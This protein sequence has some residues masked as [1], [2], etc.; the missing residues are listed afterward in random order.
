MRPAG[1]HRQKAQ[2]SKTAL[3]GADR[4]A[5]AGARPAGVVWHQQDRDCFDQEG[6]KVGA[7]EDEGE[8]MKPKAGDQIRIILNSC[9]GFNFFKIFSAIV[10]LETFVN[11][12]S[13]EIFW[14]SNPE[15]NF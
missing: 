14:S 4:G 1:S 10:L 13:L 2:E 3:P 12:K 5:W 15:I 7:P 6:S 11:L 9:R 8:W